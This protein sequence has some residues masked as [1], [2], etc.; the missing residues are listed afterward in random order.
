MSFIIFCND[1]R[2]VGPGAG[3]GDGNNEG[4]NKRKRMGGEGRGGEGRGGCSKRP[5]RGGKL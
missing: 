1:R 2:S 5:V 3:G 4:I